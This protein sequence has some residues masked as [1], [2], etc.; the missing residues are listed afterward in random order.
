[1]TG[2]AVTLT[3]VDKAEPVMTL[4]ENIVLVYHNES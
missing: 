3:D 2:A 1:M 4:S